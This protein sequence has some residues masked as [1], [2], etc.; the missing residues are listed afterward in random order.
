VRSLYKICAGRSLLPK[1]LQ[2]EVCYNPLDVPHCRGGFADVW[3][4]TYGDRQAA[5]KVLRI[6]VN[7]DL[8]KITRVSH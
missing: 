4:G 8:Q 5:V 7:S 1:S 3:K 2:I 6:D